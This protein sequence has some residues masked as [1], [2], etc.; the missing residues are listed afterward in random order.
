VNQRFIISSGGA[1]PCPPWWKYICTGTPRAFS[2]STMRTLCSGI[3]FQ[4]LKAWAMSVAARIPPA[5]GR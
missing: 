4:S 2:A 5:C 3:T 1:P